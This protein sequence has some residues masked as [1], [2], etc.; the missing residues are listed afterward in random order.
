MNLISCSSCGVVL[1]SDFL[2]FPTTDDIYNERGEV[3]LDL[4]EIMWHETENDKVVP[5]THCPV[6]EERIYQP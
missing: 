6:C 2:R 4:A 1:D 5:F 3:N